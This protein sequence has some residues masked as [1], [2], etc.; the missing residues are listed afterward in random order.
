MKIEMVHRQRRVFDAP[1]D[2]KRNTVIYGCVNCGEQWRIVLPWG[3]ND[4]R[5]HSIHMNCPCGAIIDIEVKDAGMEVYRGAGNCPH[6]GLGLG[7]RPGLL[8][9]FW[10]WMR[11]MGV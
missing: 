11:R 8:A 4:L 3:E 6:C 5:F 7:G 9:R 10:H 2:T 1:D